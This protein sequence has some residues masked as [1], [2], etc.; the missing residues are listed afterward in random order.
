MNIFAGCI[1]DTKEMAC[2]QLG[3]TSKLTKVFAF[4]L[5]KRLVLFVHLIGFDKPYGIAQTIVV[6]SFFIL[7]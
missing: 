3:F 4:S 5:W 6:S 7:A 1:E 2:H